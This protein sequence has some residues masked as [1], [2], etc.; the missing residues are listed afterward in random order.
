M[1]TVVNTN[2]I[3]DDSNDKVV[4]ENEKSVENEA[5]AK[6][7]YAIKVL[8]PTG[9][10]VEVPP[11]SLVE[12]SNV[13]KHALLDVPETCVYTNYHFEH[14]ESLNSD[15]ISI[16]DFV[17]LGSYF[18]D[19]SSQ[20]IELHIV[21]DDYDVRAARA[22][23]KRLREL[24]C[25]PPASGKLDE[26]LS[27]MTSDA[28]DSGNTN[29]QVNKIAEPETDIETE[30]N[31]LDIESL[32]KADEVFESSQL[33]LHT[34]FDEVLYRCGSDGLR[35]PESTTLSECIKSIVYSGWNPPPRRR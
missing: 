22:H 16:N 28:E 19:I 21:L 10:V 34:F 15:P 7:Q 32:P 5:V 26:K 24:I 3:Q 13:I 33:K 29:T 4:E 12:N 23:V 6:L 27:P 17:E 1:M 2:S 20:F 18:K 30:T 35:V 9:T 8:T 31:K 14:F 25:Y 11:V